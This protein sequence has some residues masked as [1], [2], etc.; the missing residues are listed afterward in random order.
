[1]PEMSIGAVDST[2]QMDLLLA[3]RSVVPHDML[4]DS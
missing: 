4:D 2:A 1:M 3:L